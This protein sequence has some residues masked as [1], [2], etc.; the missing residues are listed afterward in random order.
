M[1]FKVKSIIGLVLFIGLCVA[2]TLQAQTCC[3]A[4]APLTSTFQIAKDDAHVL[5]AQV[6]YTYR[7]INRLVDNRE[8]L[9]NDP[10]TRL[11]NNLLLKLD[12]SFKNNFAVSAVL[13]YVFQS[14]TTISEDESSAAIGDL[15]LVGQKSIALK[16]NAGLSFSVGAKLPTGKVDHLGGRGTILSPDMQSGSGTFD[17]LIGTSF[18]KFHFLTNNLTFSSNILFRKN[19]TNTNFAGTNGS[20]GRE[21]KFGDELLIEATLAHQQVWGTW[22]STPYINLNYRFSTPNREEGNISNN[23]GGQWV[24]TQAGL[25]LAPNDNF[26]FKVY[27]QIPFYQVLEGTQITTDFEVGIEFNYKIQTKRKI[28]QLTK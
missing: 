1:M 27:G 20:G 22:F 21:F 13:P 24:G 9:V 11:G 3:S 16:K 8:I 5:N 6:K 25:Q 2:N 26:N 14:R 17:F 4:G 18:T 15:L 28:K 10:R 19:T 12:Y 23:S 7:S